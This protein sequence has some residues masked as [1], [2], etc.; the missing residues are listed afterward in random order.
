MGAGAL[1]QWV[2][3]ARIT[4]EQDK[5]DLSDAQSAVE[6]AK[7]EVKIK[8]VKSKIDGEE[9]AIAETVAEQKLKAEEAR[10]AA[11]LEARGEK[12]DGDR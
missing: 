8:S 11:E 6:T 12:R 2:A 5:S 1:H 3:Q 4:V 9:A 10:E 7:L